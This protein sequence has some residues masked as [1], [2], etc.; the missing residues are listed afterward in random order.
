MV[1]SSVDAISKKRIV[2]NG[3]M[4]VAGVFL[5]ALC[6]NLLLLPNNFAFSGMSGVG[7]IV[8]KLTGLSAVT[9]IYIANIVLL[10]ISFLLLGWGPTKNTIIG[11]ILYP[12]MLTLTAP[13]ATYLLPY[14]EFSDLLVP[15][16]L[17]A[18]LYGVSDGLIYKCG[19]STG[20]SDVIVHIL[21]KYLHLPESKCLVIVNGCIIMGCLFVF[22]IEICVYSFIIML[23]GS[24]F[25]DKI[26]YGVSDSKLFYIFT[27]QPQKIKNIIKD[28]FATGFTIIPTRGGLSHHKRSI[29]MVAIASRDYFRLKNKIL[30]IDPG[31]FFIIDN[32]YEVQGGVKR[33]NLPFISD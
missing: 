22:G 21:K 1:V 20:G 9:F 11:S 27:K 4:V 16:A 24:L 5:L 18:L 25:V 12:V 29:I 2:I 28:D 6:Y 23:V 10:I 31:A 14:M 13:I 7:I 17:T 19:F 3:I 8:N 30:E 32:C 26:M 33:S 15:A